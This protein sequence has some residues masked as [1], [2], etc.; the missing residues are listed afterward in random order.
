[1]LSEISAL[2]Q[3]WRAAA[4]RAS[5]AERNL[6]TWLSGDSRPDPQDIESAYALR[7]VAT[8]RLKAFLAAVEEASRACRAR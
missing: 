4:E 8:S 2:Y 5:L 1:M 3:E 6:M 7:A